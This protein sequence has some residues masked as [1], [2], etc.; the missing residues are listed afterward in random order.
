MML[1][2]NGK[3]SGHY[4]SLDHDFSEII[5]KKVANGKWEITKKIGA[6]GEKIKTTNFTDT[7]DWFSLNF[8]NSQSGL[9]P[10]VLGFDYK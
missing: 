9:L 6:E 7:V 8:S 10:T 3:N 1:N 2:V 4:D 5:I